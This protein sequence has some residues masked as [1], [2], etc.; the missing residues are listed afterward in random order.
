MATAAEYANAH[1]AEIK[2]PLL[3][4]QG[5]ADRICVP[6]GARDFI[7]KL[8]STDKKLIEYPDTFHEPHNDLNWRQVVDDIKGWIVAHL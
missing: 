5:G 1:A 8:T 6:E 2:L 7:A 4:V 3:I